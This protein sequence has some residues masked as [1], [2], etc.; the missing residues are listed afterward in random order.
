MW[1]GTFRT[2]I[3]YINLHQK[4]L[5]PAKLLLRTDIQ[6]WFEL[7]KNQDEPRKSRYR[8]RLCFRNLARFKI[9]PSR[10]NDIFTEKGALHPTLE[11]N[12]Q[13]ILRHMET[14]AHKDVVANLIEEADKGLPEEY[15]K[16]QR[17]KSSAPHMHATLNM[18]RCVYVQTK[19]NLAFYNHPL[20]V[21]LL[22]ANGA[23]M[24]SSLRKRGDAAKMMSF[25]SEKMLIFWKEEVVKSDRPFSIIVDSSHDKSNNHYLVVSGVLMKSCQVFARHHFGHNYHVPHCQLSGQQ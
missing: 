4:S 21:Q 2:W 17:T 6:R 14:M 19:L 25:I 12:R 22:T 15:T 8:C 20:L 23:N 18:F 24:G 1:F 5:I 3:D 11:L 16:A 13:A 9:N 7:I 10:K